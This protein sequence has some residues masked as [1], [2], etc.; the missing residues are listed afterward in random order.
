M[1]ASLLIRI[2]SFFARFSSKPWS[3]FES[4]G[5]TPDGILSFSIS[6]NDAFVDKLKYQNYPGDTD[7]EIVQF[8]YLSTRVL[9]ENLLPT[10]KDEITDDV[11]NPAAMPNL[12][13]DTS[14]IAR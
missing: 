6:W 13:K 2:K 8:F 11:V 10:G 3:C 7:E 9:P 1:K 4:P 14:F 12:S 5:A